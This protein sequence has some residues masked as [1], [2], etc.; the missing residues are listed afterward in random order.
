MIVG[1]E[2]PRSIASANRAQASSTCSQL[3]KITQ[4]LAK[5]GGTVPRRAAFR[6]SAGT[7]GFPAPRRSEELR[8]VERGEVKGPDGVS[9]GILHFGRNPHAS[10]VLPIPPAPASVNRR[11]FPS[12][13][14]SSTSSRSRPTNDVSG[15]GRS[16]IGRAWCSVVLG[17][18]FGDRS[19]NRY[20]R[21]ASVSTH[22]RHRALAPER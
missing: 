2:A 15:S 13:L 22:A 18:Q 4:P 19:T 11:F 12:S 1:S 7:Q 9:V 5:R 8:I 17:P 21:R 20:P 14:L 10:R 6:P 3:S 16:A